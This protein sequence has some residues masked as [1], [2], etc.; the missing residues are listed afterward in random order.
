MSTVRPEAPSQESSDGEAPA[1]RL[2]TRWA[3]IVLVAGL[4]AVAS[5]PVGGAVTAIGV[6][7]AV[8]AALHKMID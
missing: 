5:S 6:A 4:A 3:V 7:T 2:P 8:A 1:R